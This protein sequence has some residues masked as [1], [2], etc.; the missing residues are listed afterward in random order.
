M[1]IRTWSTGEPY[2]RREI[3]IIQMLMQNWWL[4]G[5]AGVL[6]AVISVFYLIMQSSH[7]PVTFHAWNSTVVFLGKLAFAAGACTTAAGLLRPTG[8]RCWLV[9]LNGL[10]LSTLGFIPIAFLRF[11][12]SFLVIALLIILM[13]LSAGILEIG[14]ARTL[15]RHQPS[16]RVW[17]LWLTG[18]ISIGFAFVFLALALRWIKMQPGSHTDL[19]WLGLY[20]GFTATCMLIS[21]ARLRRKRFY[22][23]N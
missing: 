14:I 8:A 11:P 22:T 4:L 7:G 3:R 18:L 21:A 15:L 23:S 17:A 16:A 13:A 1:Q 6:E 19:L 20:F 12:I 2:D 5:L 10:A 9:V